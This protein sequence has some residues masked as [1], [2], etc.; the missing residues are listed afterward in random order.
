MNE[1]ILVRFNEVTSWA[2]S[3]V[4]NLTQVKR[5]PSNYPPKRPDMADVGEFVH[6]LEM[7]PHD[8]AYTA[9]SREVTGVA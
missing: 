8:H 6:P 5:K 9:T 3:A 4:F 1:I 7:L 2:I